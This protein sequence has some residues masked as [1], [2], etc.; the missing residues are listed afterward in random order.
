MTQTTPPTTAGH[1][2]LYSDV[3]RETIVR[4]TFEP[5]LIKLGLSEAQLTM[6]SQAELAHSLQRLEDALAHPEGFGV[7]RLKLTPQ[8]YVVALGEFVL[9]LRDDDYTAAPGAKAVDS[10]APVRCPCLSANRG[11]RRPRNSRS[12]A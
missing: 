8:G 1:S 3:A 5:Q 9:S 12:S 4:R 7:L 2:D 10:G 11:L 6:Q